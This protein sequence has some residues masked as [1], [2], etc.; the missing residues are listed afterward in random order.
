MLYHMCSM[1]RMVWPKV[2]DRGVGVEA[3]SGLRLD[4]L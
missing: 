3:D 1:L 2:A 4:V